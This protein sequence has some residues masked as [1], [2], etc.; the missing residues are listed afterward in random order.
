MRRLLKSDILQKHFAHGGWSF[1]MIFFTSRV[2]LNAQKPR[3]NFSAQ[4]CAWFSKH[5]VTKLAFLLYKEQLLFGA[6]LNAY[7]SDV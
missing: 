3:C 1:V 5:V 6:T 2:C 4:L 7:H